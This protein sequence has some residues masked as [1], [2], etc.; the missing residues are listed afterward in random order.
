MGALATTFGVSQ[1]MLPAHSGQGRSYFLTRLL[2]EVVFEEVDLAGANR[3]LEIQRRW[4]QRAAY[5]GAVVVTILAVLAWTTSFTRNEV[6]VHRFK[7][8]L[9]AF[10]DLKQATPAAPDDFEALLQP[11]GA[12]RQANAVYADFNDGVPLLMGM[13]LYQG[14]GLTEASEDAYRRELG[15]T[16]LPAIR[17]RLEGHLGAGVSDPDF[18]YEALKT[19]L[20]LGDPQH[21]DNEQLRL[22]MGLDWRNQF[23]TAPEKQGQLQNHLSAM[24]EL[25]FESSELDDAVIG[26]A[27]LSLNQ[28]P[29]SNLLYGR[30]KRDYAAVDKHP[31]R[32]S[33]AIGPSGKKVFR[34]IS[35]EALE[36]GIPGLFTYDGYHDFFKKQVKNVAEQSS[37]ENWILNP[38]T[39]EL[40]EPEIEQLQKELR[41][42][43]FADYIRAWNKL[44]ADIG[45]VEFRD[46]QHAVEVLDLVSGPLSPMRGLL[47]SVAHNT[48][49]ERPDGLLAK[50]A[51]QVNK[52]SATQNRLARLL[53]TV[54]ESETL[55][56]LDRPA[57]VVDK[58]F[59]RLDALVQAQQGGLAPIDQ[60]LDLLSQLYAQLESM[61][62]GLGTDALSVATG[63][64]GGGVMRRVQVEGA[65][66]PEPVKKWL[67]QIASSSRG[68]TMGGARSQVNREWKS[69]VAPVCQQALVGRYPV[70]KD[71]RKEMTL[72]D[73]GRLFAPGGLID[74]FFKNNLQAFVDQ[75]RGTWRWK[76]VGNATLGISNATLR[77]FQRAALIRDTFFQAGGATPSVSFGLKPVYLDANVKSFRLDLEGQQFRYRHGPTRVQRAQWP[78]PDGTGQVRIQFE[79]DSGARLSSTT[80]GPWA[81]FRI[82]DQA[83][84]KST[85]ADRF[86]AT[87]VKSGRKS[88]W[89]IRADSV[90]NPF[91]MKQLQQFRCTGNL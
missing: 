14:N 71:S 21:L 81:W 83:Q 31:F 78:N 87:F 47:Q 43:Y 91:M 40:T 73:F 57:E 54:S 45:V 6:Y 9:E 69:T 15:A 51:D 66:Q 64:G 26:R 20:M 25:G 46:I 5:S 27:R 58:Q 86:I 17:N 37:E 74:N 70:Y 80:D 34:R 50:A 36:S 32:L 52:A 72:A 67:Q 65:R 89:E 30:M 22:W 13:G 61:S 79:D 29:L 60:L 7:D 49:L 76:P 2:K 44:L 68:V 88:S 75:S 8:K 38:D 16:L 24:L 42:L 63:A 35:G 19:Y 11:L 55:P 62:V 48:T 3:K 12:L 84:L 41:Q 10:Q 39:G 56:K 33:D 28:V 53:Q 23:S 59:E 77:Q 90:V 18:L 82:L 85:S 4:L 1:Q